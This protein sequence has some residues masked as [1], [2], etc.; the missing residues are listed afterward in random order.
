VGAAVGA[1]VGSGVGGAFVG[2]SVGLLLG[3]SVGGTAVGFSVG[4][5]EGALLGS[6]VGL[7]VVGAKVGELVVGRCDGAAE[8]LLVQSPD[9]SY[10]IHKL[11]LTC[12]T[13]FTA[14]D[15]ELTPDCL[16]VFRSIATDPTPLNKALF[17]AKLGTSYTGWFSITPILCTIKEEEPKK[18]AT[19]SN[20]LKDGK[21]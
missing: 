21:N 12:S 1:A 11:T 14:N 5:D 8:G 10:V 16:W 7:R 13:K 17:T 20:G 3:A 15:G 9:H 2:A 6:V 18:S 4:A 19:P